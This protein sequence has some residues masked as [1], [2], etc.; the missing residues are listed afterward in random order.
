MKWLLAIKVKKSKLKFSFYVLTFLKFSETS[1]SLFPE[2][3]HWQADSGLTCFEFAENKWCKNGG[4]G[5][6]WNDSWTWDKDSEGLDA[7]D[8]CLVCGAKEGRY[9]NFV[10]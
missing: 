3:T 9:K 7:R 8:A 1:F 4:V 2:N 5:S 6:A 10:L